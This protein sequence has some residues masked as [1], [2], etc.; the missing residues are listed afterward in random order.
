M[1]PSM[2][3]GLTCEGSTVPTMAIFLP[4]RFSRTALP[5]PIG[6]FEPK[7]RMPLRFG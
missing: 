3:S 6:P 2:S 7:A 1:V 4:S 5:A